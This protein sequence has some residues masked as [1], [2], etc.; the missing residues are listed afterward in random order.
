VA[1]LVEKMI[2]QAK[3]DPT[4]LTVH[5]AE[6]RDEGETLLEDLKSKLNCVESYLM[7]VP[8][9]LGVHSGPGAVGIAYYVEREDVGL[10]EKL[11][12]RLGRLSSQA[13]EAIR[14]RLP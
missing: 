8:V 11:E 13:K 9:E 4:H 10:V 12:Q 6:D 7:R 14:S 3:E 5:Y 1:T 2:D